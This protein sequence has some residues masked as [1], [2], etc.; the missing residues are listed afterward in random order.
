MQI[1]QLKN[2]L[3]HKKLEHKKD[4]LQIEALE[5]ETKYLRSQAQ[6]EER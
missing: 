4:K 1:G 6:D 2:E 5:L 3:H